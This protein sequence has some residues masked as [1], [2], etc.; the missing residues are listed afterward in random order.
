MAHHGEFHKI[1]AQLIFVVKV[2]LNTQMK[3]VKI[4]G[5]IAQVR[6]KAHAVR[7][8]M[9]VSTVAEIIGIEKALS[10]A[11]PALHAR[12]KEAMLSADGRAALL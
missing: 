5:V 10:Q 2:R 9:V 7:D 1:H 4:P 6:Q 3:N 12:V 11:G 8:A